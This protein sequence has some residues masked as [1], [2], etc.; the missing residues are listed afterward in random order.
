MTTSLP[1]ID[2]A[3]DAALEIS[4]WDMRSTESVLTQDGVAKGAWML[5][6]EASRHALKNI[7]EAEDATI[8]DIPAEYVE[9]D[10]DVNTV[11]Y[12]LPEI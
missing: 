3:V 9:D 8:T 6:L 10:S 5:D 12:P 11:Q 1:N 2:V 7:I 4:D